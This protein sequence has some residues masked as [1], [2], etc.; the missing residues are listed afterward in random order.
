MQIQYIHKSYKI[1][2]Y[3]HMHLNKLQVTYLVD[4]LFNFSQSIKSK[5][6]SIHN[7]P[8]NRFIN[9]K[10]AKLRTAAIKMSSVAY[11]SSVRRSA[12]NVHC[13]S[14]TAATVLIFSPCD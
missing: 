6:L 2:L 8:K 4:K 14:D 13:Q 11:L 12:Y 9:Q 1:I 10:I 5:I 7:L 3:I